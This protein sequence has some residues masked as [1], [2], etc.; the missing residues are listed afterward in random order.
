[1][2]YIELRVHRRLLVLRRLLVAGVVAAS[3]VLTTSGCFFIGDCGPEV[4]VGITTP[5]F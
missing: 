3:I 4:C 2:Q 5:T 1:M